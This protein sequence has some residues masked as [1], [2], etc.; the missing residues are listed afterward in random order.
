[1]NDGP[2]V[3]IV[4]D[5]K[6]QEVRRKLF[7]R[8]TFDRVSRQYATTAEKALT[9]GEFNNLSLKITKQAMSKAE[10]CKTEAESIIKDLGNSFTFEAFKTRYKESVFHKVASKPVSKPKNDISSLFDSYYD[11]NP[12]LA[13]S[14]KESYDTVKNW[15]LAFAPDC[16]I[17][18]LTPE[19]VHNLE[20]Y[21][22]DCHLNAQKEKASKRK[23]ETPITEMSVNT[24]GIYFRNLK[25]ICNHAIKQGWLIENPLNNYDIQSTA[26]EKR[27]LSIEDFNA[28]K[29]Y[30]STN[31][32]R[33]FARDFFILSF[34]MA[35]MNA[36]DIFSLKN[37]NFNE[38][39]LTFDRKK[40]GVRVEM[41]LTQD[42]IDII[43]KYG[44]LTRDLPNNYVFPFYVDLDDDEKIRQRKH[45]LIRRINSGLEAICKDLNIEKITS[46]NARHTYATLSRDLGNLDASQ[47]QKLLGHANLTTTQ[48]YLDS[49]SKPAQAKNQSFLEALMNGSKS[50]KR[51]KKTSK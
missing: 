5:A 37:M 42:A 50:K 11:S 32:K 16:I 14:T 23:V 41:D 36:G 7:L 12:D 47:I 1:M 46:Y 45:W 8:V 9:D 19:F 25:A 20:V 28:I 39:H 15:I 49:L 3:K 44:R 17:S 33:Q 29:D 13:L 51:R 27:A 30:R 6:S 10:K 24:L 48:A 34:L 31:T 26:R 22:K 43:Q 18:D 4:L 21:I 40:T 38:H 35:G 2:V